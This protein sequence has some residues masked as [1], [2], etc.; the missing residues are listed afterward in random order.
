MTR[1]A[2]RTP[3]AVLLACTCLLVLLSTATQARAQ[4]ADDLVIER[5][6]A[7][8][9][10]E[11]SGTVQVTETIEVD[12][13]EEHHGIL[14]EIPTSYALAEDD[15]QV[16]LP[17]DRVA[18]DFNRVIEITDLTVTS[19]GPDDV[20]LTEES[21]GIVIRVGDPDIEVTGRH[22]YELSYKVR[23]ALN[24]F[25][26]RSELVWDVT[27]S[28]WESVINAASAAVTAP[29]VLQVSCARGPEGSTE[30]CEQAE[31]AAGGATF[32]TGTLEPGEGLTI[33]V[34]M[35]VGAVD[36]PPPLIEERWRLGPAL[37]GDDAVWPLTGLATVIGAA[38]IVAASRTRR[39]RIR[40]VTADSGV[41][42]TGPM[43]RGDPPDGLRPAQLRMLTEERADAT[44]LGATLLDLAARGH[45]EIETLDDADDDD[46]A[47][48]RFRRSERPADRGDL[49]AYERELL[50]GLFSDG[51][52]VTAEEIAE[53]HGEDRTRFE[54]QVK[55]DA[56]DRGWFTKP[57]EQLRVARGFLG[58]GLVLLAVLVLVLA[59]VLSRV[60][61][62]A[63]PL[64][65][66]AVVIAVIVYRLPTRTS[67][68]KRLLSQARGYEDYLTAADGGL[69]SD[70]RGPAE[71]FGSTL[72]FAMAIGVAPRWVRR[73]ETSGLST[74]QW[75]PAY[76]LPLMVASDNDPDRFATSV[77]SFGD[78]VTP[79]PSAST[80][81]GVSSGGGV[82]GGGGGGW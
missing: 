60:A 45:L 35:A 73:F 49:L 42:M 37:A 31:V 46:E 72:P 23:G 61:L 41:A 22:T 16:Q 26:E 24:S 70:G 15:T 80:G 65:I 56:M 57:P 9:V 79:A 13:L 11:P 3:A 27:G 76:Y 53:D 51:A 18:A 74:S 66:A 33:S 14:R 81:S 75:M 7:D 19:S 52:S 34:G 1:A 43:L 71:V 10:V 25:S 54:K 59:L 58:A 2:H 5:F 50:D 78:V 62:A 28:E 20:E 82:G 17:E 47:G 48:Y 69:P 21:G 63:L 64:L 39:R 38:G 4:D 12:F 77:A 6:S 40:A 68:G 29:Q 44:S 30:P 32:S 67:E 55:A 36:V 8:I